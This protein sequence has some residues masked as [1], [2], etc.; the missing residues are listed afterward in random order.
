MRRWRFPSLS[1]HGIEG[2]YAERGAKTV[3]PRKVI[4]KFSIRLVPDQDPDDIIGKVCVWRGESS[5]P[6]QVKTFI[7]SE[8]KQSGST[9]NVTV[10]CT[11]GARAWV[12]DFDHPNF[13]AAREATKEV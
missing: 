12:A 11:H 5:Q 8:F 1:L 2:A 13:V 4:G 7:E 3:I 10:A 9:N 6:I